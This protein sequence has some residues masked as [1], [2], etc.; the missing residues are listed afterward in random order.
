MNPS[1][2]HSAVI[3]IIGQVGLSSLGCQPLQKYNYEFKALMVGW[4]A[5]WV[6]WHINLCWLFNAK[7]ISMK[8]DL[9]Q[10]NQFECKYNLVMKNVSISRYSV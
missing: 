2:L 3:E 9:F 1:L 4:L 6:F 7:S 5:C 8:I 10:T